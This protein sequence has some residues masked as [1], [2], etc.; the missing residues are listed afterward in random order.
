MYAIRSYYEIDQPGN[1]AAKQKR[2]E[3]MFGKVPEHVTLVPIDFDHERLEVKLASTGY[4]RNARTFFIWEAVSQY[5]QEV[6]VRG[7]FDFLASAPSGSRL[8]FTYVQKDFI[9]GKELY[10]QQYIYRNNFV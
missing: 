9:E 5:L 1:I 8:V 4:S 6:S 10:G 7:T 2:L 3:K